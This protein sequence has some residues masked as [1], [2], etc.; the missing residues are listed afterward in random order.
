VEAGLDGRA[1]GMLDVG[2]GLH[3]GRVAGEGELLQVGDGQRGAGHHCADRWHDPRRRTGREGG[4]GGGDG[5]GCRDCCEKDSTA[6]SAIAQAIDEGSQAS[7][8]GLLRFGQLPLTPG[9]LCLTLGQL[10]LS[11]GQG[12]DLFVRTLLGCS[13]VRKSAI[14]SSQHAHPLLQKLCDSV[15]PPVESLLHRIDAS[16]NIH[17]A[18][19]PLKTKRTAVQSFDPGSTCNGRHFTKSQDSAMRKGSA[20]SR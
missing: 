8:C 9:E 13:Q 2:P 3:G 5:R 10:P 16:L 1:A 7:I 18:R 12:R 6:I 11:F 14:R 17:G 4:C 19:I 15:Q 20:V